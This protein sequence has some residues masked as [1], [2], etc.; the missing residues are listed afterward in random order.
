MDAYLNDKRMLEIR[1]W[2]SQL[3]DSPASCAPGPTFGPRLLGEMQKLAAAVSVGHATNLTFML[4]RIACDTDAATE[5]G[6]RYRQRLEVEAL[7][8]P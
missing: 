6:H 7:P 5:T 2:Q 3:P 8:Q 1:I 4:L